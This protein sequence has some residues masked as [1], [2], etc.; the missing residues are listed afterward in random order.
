MTVRITIEKR[1]S[2]WDRI[3]WPRVKHTYSSQK[4]YPAL[5]TNQPLKQVNLVSPLFYGQIQSGFP[6]F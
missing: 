6:L 4:K 2:V 1:A 3:L 5:A